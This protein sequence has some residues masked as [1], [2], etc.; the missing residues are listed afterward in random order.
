MKNVA[1]A[2]VLVAALWAASGCAS[3][4]PVLKGV[5][6][7]VLNVDASGVELAFDVDVENQLPI[8]LKSTSGRYALDIAEARLL[9]SDQVP[10]LDLPAG[11]VGTVTLPARVEYADL[12]KT[13]Q[14]M[15]TAK[16]LPY[17]M[18]GAFL[19]PMMGSDYELP[20]SHEGTIPGPAEAV[21]SRAGDFLKLP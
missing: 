19:F 7:R 9:S 21:R 14:S 13:A 8:P 4:R 17:R 10:A 11:E 1:M 18:Q 12:I 16:E 15:A 3:S 2:G 5:A 20:F 6:A